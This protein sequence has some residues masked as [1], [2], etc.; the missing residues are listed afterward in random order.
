MIKLVAFDLNGTI[1]ADLEAVLR[2]NNAV[3]RHFGKKEISLL[4]YQTHFRVPI[5][6]YWA[7]LGYDPNYFDQIS[8]EQEK[9][10]INNY[11][12][13]ESKLRTRSGVRDLIKFLTSANIESIIF[14]NH[15]IPHI[16]LQL[17]RFKLH[18]YFNKI[19]GRPLNTRDHQHK[20]F[21]DTYLADYVQ[22]KNYKPNE[23]VVVGDTDEEI[24]IGKKFGYVTVALSGGHQTTKRLKEKNP[25]YLINNLTELK[26]II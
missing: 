12:P 19:L 5:K 18:H 25:D 10:F 1:I 8:A 14:S 4:E 9:V 6:D 26:R 2:A 16:E 20:R 23:V 17:R 24:E 21:K 7:S 11:E 13:E 3:L 22:S 15:I